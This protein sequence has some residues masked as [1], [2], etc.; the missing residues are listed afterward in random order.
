MRTARGQCGQSLASD[1]SDRARACRAF[2]PVLYPPW[3]H[4]PLSAS[5][6][7]SPQKKRAF[8]WT[9][10]QN[11]LLLC[12]NWKFGPSTMCV[13]MCPRSGLGGPSLACWCG[14]GLIQGGSLGWW[15]GWWPQRLCYLLCA[16]GGWLP[17]LYL[18]VLISKMDTRRVAPA[19]SKTVSGFAH[20]PVVSFNRTL[21]CLQLAHEIQGC[22]SHSPDPQTVE[23]C[24]EGPWHRGMC[25][26]CLHLFKCVVILYPWLS[27]SG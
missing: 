21:R 8:M 17:P 18:S 6:L 3:G 7:R 20:Q 27:D 24:R 12:I 25:A 10:G 26:L 4:R 23:G 16:F 22:P 14:C 15:S 11:F 19:V 2:C 13:A 1:G 9:C 5:V